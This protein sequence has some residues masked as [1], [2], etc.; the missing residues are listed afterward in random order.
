MADVP[1]S[2][3]GVAKEFFPD[4][5]SGVLTIPTGAAAGTIATITPP[6]GKRIRLYLLTVTTGSQQ[7]NISVALAGVKKITNL[8]LSEGTGSPVTGRFRVGFAGTY[9]SIDKLD[10]KKDQALTIIKEPSGATTQDIVY[11]YAYGD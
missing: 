10:G 5:V 6:A 4:F 11:S 7:E 9:A 1:F 3:F 8:S 2:D